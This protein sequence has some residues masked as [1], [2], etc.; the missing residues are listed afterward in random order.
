MDKGRGLSTQ[1]ILSPGK[2]KG[3]EPS[4]NFDKSQ[5]SCG[6]FSEKVEDHVHQPSHSFEKGPLTEADNN[7]DYDK[8]ND[9]QYGNKKGSRKSEASS[10]ENE[11]HLDN[12][13]DTDKMTD[14][15][16]GKKKG[17]RKS[18]ASSQN[19]QHL[20]RLKSE[21][22]QPSSRNSDESRRQDAKTSRTLS[23]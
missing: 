17:S 5:G 19:E 22:G 6:S 2:G 9:D 14:D 4:N 23:R 3:T 11:Q 1:P 13:R 21:G 18:E 12:I 8:M 7:R 20:D 10:L 15:Q 16:S